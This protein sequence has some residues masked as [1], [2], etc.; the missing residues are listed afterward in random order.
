MGR[1]ILEPVGSEDGEGER[2]GRD[3]GPKVRVSNAN[4]GYGA[5]LDSKNMGI[6]HSVTKSESN[7]DKI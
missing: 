1:K 2:G 4:V 6:T 5:V 3:Q 7:W